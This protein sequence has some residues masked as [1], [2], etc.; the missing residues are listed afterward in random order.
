MNAAPASWDAR[1]DYDI[2]TGSRRWRLPVVA[3]ISTMPGNRFFGQLLYEA[4]SARPRTRHEQHMLDCSQITI[5]DL[6]TVGR[7]EGHTLELKIT[8]GRYSFCNRAVITVL[9]MWPKGLAVRGDYELVA[10][11]FEPA[12]NPGLLTTWVC[13]GAP[14]LRNVPPSWGW[15]RAWSVAD[16]S[17]AEK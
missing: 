10:T 16:P 11:S 13:R 5:L 14:R 4:D 3:G 1:V 2:H 7:R 17:T 12:G 15:D 6:P 8:G 9:A